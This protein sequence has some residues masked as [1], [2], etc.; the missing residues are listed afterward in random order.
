MLPW[1]WSSWGRQGGRF[2]ELPVPSRIPHLLF[3]FPFKQTLCPHEGK[4][5]FHLSALLLLFWI[6][7]FAAPGLT[8]GMWDLAS[9][10]GIKHRPP[11]LGVWSPWTPRE[12]P[13][14]PLW[15]HWQGCQLDPPGYLWRRCWRP[16]KRCRHLLCS[17]VAAPHFLKFPAKVGAAAAPPGLGEI[18]FLSLEAVSNGW[19]LASGVSW[20]LTPGECCEFIFLT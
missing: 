15:P 8:C 2:W 3:L 1:L 5:S 16:A 17:F 13:L 11:A 12:A 4:A 20:A 9:Q 18:P 7:Y 14:P 10:P 19:W 6:N